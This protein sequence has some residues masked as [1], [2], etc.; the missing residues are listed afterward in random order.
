MQALVLSRGVKV[1]GTGAGNE[2]D[3]VTH[4]FLPL[5][6]GAVGAQF[7]QNHFDATLFNGTQTRV[8]HA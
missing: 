3:L 2:L 5:N 7:G 8:G 6:L 4:D 1:A